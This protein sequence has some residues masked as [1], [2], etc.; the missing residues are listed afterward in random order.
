MRESDPNNKT[1]EFDN[2]KLNVSLID[3]LI[4]I[5]VSGV[6]TDEVALKLIQ[7]LDELIDRIPDS[8]IRVWDGSGIA[9]EAYQLSTKCIQQ[10]ASWSRG[11][12]A[13]RPGSV[14]YMVATND[15]SYGMTRMYQIISTLEENGVIV[16]RSIHELPPAIREKLHI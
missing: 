15:V 14:V 3:N 16:L 6:Y 2:A 1:L 7:Y 13:K 4:Y 12:L 5:R 8:H 9:K 10:I 11:I